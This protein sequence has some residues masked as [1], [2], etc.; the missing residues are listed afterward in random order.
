MSVSRTSGSSELFI[1]FLEGLGIR[2]KTLLGETSEFC[3]SRGF[4]AIEEFRTADGT[5]IDLAI[6]GKNDER[7]VAVEFENSYKWMKQRTLYNAIKAHRAGFK[8][9]IIVYP[10]NN[11]PLKNSWVFDYIKNELG[12]EVALVKPESLLMF[13]EK[14]IGIETET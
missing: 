7:I 10:F 3:S 12:I 9:L 4:K 11:D 5:R 13:L 1:S 2:I 6:F 14:N 8:R